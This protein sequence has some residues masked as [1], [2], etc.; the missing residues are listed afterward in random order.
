MRI[1]SLW[2]TMH[3]SESIRSH[4]F[5]SKFFDLFHSVYPELKF[6]LMGEWEPPRAEF[7]LS[8]AI[9]EWEQNRGTKDKQKGRYIF[10]GTSPYEFYVLPHWYMGGDVLWTDNLSVVFSEQ[11]QS[12]ERLTESSYRLIELLKGLARLGTPLYGKAYQDS[13]WKAKN[14]TN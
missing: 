6:N 1:E 14:F 5:A 4:T 8:K 11:A 13:E 7:D 10:L 3:F 12:S 2:V 9:K